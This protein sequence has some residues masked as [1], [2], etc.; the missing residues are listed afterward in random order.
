MSQPALHQ[1]DW[2]LGPLL[3]PVRLPRTAR[4]AAGLS[5]DSDDGFV[6]ADDPSH[7]QATRRDGVWQWRTAASEGQWQ[8]DAAQHGCGVGTGRV[9]A[10]LY[11]TAVLE[12]ALAAM[13]CEVVER[14]GLV[15]HAATIACP[16]G[17]GRAV[18]VAGR[19]GAGK[20]TLAQRFASHWVNEEHAF[21]LP[22]AAG[23]QAWYLRQYRGQRN[24]SSQTGTLHAVYLLDPDDRT[25]THRERLADRDAHAG[26]LANGYIPDGDGLATLLANALP[27][28]GTVPVYRL[29]HALSTPV[30]ALGELLF[31]NTGAP[32]A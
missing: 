16:A 22:T 5:L 14:H 13:W 3:L 10:N 32:N 25:Q 2:R 28:L 30:E 7:W 9:A 17:D 11:R 18:V 4:K 27:L 24:H 1:F 21:L 19:S 23:W 8:L 20:S 12:A 6:V 26:L 31:A 29:T 15:L